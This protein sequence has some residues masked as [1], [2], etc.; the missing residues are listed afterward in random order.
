MLYAAAGEEEMIK[1]SFAAILE[2]NKVTLR[3]A[4]VDKMEKDDRIEALVVYIWN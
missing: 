4:Q 1:I 2:G 3:R